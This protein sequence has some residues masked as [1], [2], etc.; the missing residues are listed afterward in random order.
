MKVTAIIA[1]RNEEAYIANCLRH[2]VRNGVDFVI[3]DN[4][5]TDSSLD[6]CR[7]REF[8]NNLVDIQRLPYAGVFALAEQLAKK[9]AILAELN[10]DWVIHLDADEVMHSYREDEPLC[11]AISRADAD[12]FCAINFDEF[13]FLPVDHDYLPDTPGRQPMRYYYFFQPHLEPRQLRCWRK[14]AELSNIDSGGHGLTGES[15]R[16]WPEHLALRHYIVRSQEHAFIKY[17]TRRY[18]AAEL[19]RGWHRARAD[20]AASQFRFPPPEAL[21]RLDDPSDRNL[22]RSDPW[23]VNYWLMPGQGDVAPIVP[24]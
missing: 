11:D 24:R 2:L 16:V 15:L 1:I 5:S 20:K 18:A 21:R 19:E 17:S 23:H 7:R 4:D 3:V 9:A 8:A 12:G 6:I 13:N 14:S 22:D 10:T